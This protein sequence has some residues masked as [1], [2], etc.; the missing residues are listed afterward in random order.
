MDE[1]RFELGSN[2]VETIFQISFD[3]CNERAFD[4]LQAC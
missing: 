3:A 2:L 1:A 4:V